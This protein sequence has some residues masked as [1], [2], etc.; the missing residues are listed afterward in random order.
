MAN[1]QTF[2]WSGELNKTVTHSLVT[3]FGLDFLLFEDKVGGDVDTTHNVRKGV[4]ATDSEKQKY[5][6]RD[7]YNSHDYHSHKNY[8][9]KGRAD[10]AKHQA[11]ELHD[12]YRNK[13]MKQGEDRQL[14]HILAA[15]KI[16]DDRARVL[17]GVDGVELANQ[18][19]NLQSTYWVINNAK[20]DYT[21]DEFIEKLPKLIDNRKQAMQKRQEKLKSMPEDTLQQKHKKRQLEDKI[22]QDQEYI[23]GLES[24]DEK[25]MREE[26]AKAQ[27]Y[28]DAQIDRAYYGSSKFFKKAGQAAISQGFR[29][30]ARQA[31]G[32]IMA[33]IWFELKQAIPNILNK[34]KVDFEPK[35]FWHELKITLSN[36]L[37]RV[38]LRFKDA[39][40]AFKD[41]FL[42]GILSSITTTILNIFLT[43]TKL[44]GKL[45]RESWS[46]LTQVIKLLVLNPQQLAF[47]DLM[48]EITRLILASVST[49]LGTVVH[50]KLSTV[51]AMPFGTEIAAFLSALFTGLLMVGVGYFVDFSPVMKKVWNFLNG[52][53][54]K[55]DNFLNHIK[56]IN[57]ELDQ[58]TTELARIEF[59]L[60]PQELAA[61][62]DALAYAADE[63]EKGQVLKVE[64][65][66]RGIE[67]P[68][69]MGNRSSVLAW[70][71]GIAKK[72]HG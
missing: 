55:Y 61:L 15:K 1:A 19:S 57:A 49:I 42:G 72:R 10:K 70:V 58:Y 33:E 48:R 6:N 11:G 17:A 26:E 71:Q 16:H 65:E 29:M 59:N 46:N 43:T 5:D 40:T 51:L 50:Q 2:D 25:A 39:L 37:E 21:V 68:Y 34:C 38:K 69:E 47:G 64:V 56:E 4:Y 53:K 44:W 52:L 20:K 30:G 62:T 66:K 32:L 18:D 24:V 54:N 8:I 36:I 22:K 12:A 60:N 31:I 45:I 28:Y 13:T 23:D 67:L 3:T 63:Y 9:Q 41:N 7:E 35:T 27:K 14:D